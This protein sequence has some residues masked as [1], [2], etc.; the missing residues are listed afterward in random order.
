MGTRGRPLGSQSTIDFTLYKKK[1]RVL[2]KSPRKPQTKAAGKMRAEVAADSTTITT[3]FYKLS[4]NAELLAVPPDL[5]NHP[6][7][8]SLGDLYLD[9]VGGVYQPWLWRLDE[10]SVPHWKKI[11]VGHQ[12]DDGKHLIVTRKNHLLSWVMPSYYRQ[13]GS[14]YGSA[15]G[16]GED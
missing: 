12:R 1:T 15:V 2:T 9:R 11:S 8:L 14:G 3:W 13:V 6:E 5:A 16:E 7:G 4:P 10:I